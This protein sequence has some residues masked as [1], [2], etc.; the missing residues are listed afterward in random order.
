MKSFRSWTQQIKQ[1]QGHLPCSSR[2]N[3]AK[4]LQLLADS[5]AICCK[6]IRYYLKPRPLRSLLLEVKQSK[7]NKK[8]TGKYL[9]PPVLIV[10]AIFCLT[11]AIGH[12]FYNEPR[13]AIGTIAPQTL[14]APTS[15]RVIDTTTTEFNRKA[16]RTAAVP[17][18][19][20]NPH[21]NREI[22]QA[23]ERLFQ[24]GSQL[25]HTAGPFPFV[26]TSTLSTPTQRYLRRV[27]PEIWQT[28]LATAQ[29]EAISPS[30]P[31]SL[32]GEPLPVKVAQEQV[33][34]ELQ[35][36]RRSQTNEGF[37]ALQK[38][39]E[40]ARSQ[41]ASA[42]NLLKSISSNSAD[43]L[44]NTT[45]LDLT[46]AEWQQVQ[47]SSQEV[48]QRM[49][50]QG[51]TPGL[52]NRD[53]E[54][55]VQLQF[56]DDL[57]PIAQP[58]AQK[59]LLA[60]LKPNL[61][62]DSEQTQLRAEQAA[63]AVKAVVIKIRQGEVIVQ[64]G[65][66][67]TPE[68]FILLDY[69]HLSRRGVHWGRLLGFSGLVTIALFIFLGIEQRLHPAPLRRRD[70]FLILLLALTAPLVITVNLPTS[71]LPTIGLLVGSF[72]SSTLG[73]AAVGLLSLVLPLGVEVTWTT[74]AASAIGGL[75]G[76]MMA[77]R[78][79][80]REELALAGGVVGLTQGIVYLL[81]HLI[82]SSA[83]SPTWYAIFTGAGMQA[84]MG[85][86]WSVAALGISPYLE[87]FF[88]LVTP[89]RLAE[90]SNP[91]RPLLQRLAAEAPG[92]FQHT[93]FVATLAEAAAR[94]LGDNVELVRAGTL[95]HDIGKMHDPLGFIENQ[96]G[97]PNK[98]DLINN[99]WQSAEIIK[100]HVS[101]G[102]AMARRCRLPKAIQAFIP[103]HQGTLAISYFLHQ[104]LDQSRNHP[105][106]TVNEAD[107]HYDGPIPQTRET[108]IVMLADS[109][110]A[111]LRS[112]KDATP[113]EAL[114]MVNRILRARWQDNQ[115]VD[116]GLTRM[117]M[118]R[119]AEIFVQVWL[120]FNHQR[121][122][123]PK[124]A[125]GARD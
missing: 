102:L 11:S 66:R 87:Q 55:A 2:L 122:P 22:Q 63:E 117:E 116:S 104:A 25:R 45:F 83:E 60:V 41:Y 39:I 27:P 48:L 31:P 94:A 28:L 35:N 49:L 91:N 123:Y 29:D 90:L 95:Y 110:E 24:Q 38:Q 7:R 64:A 3:W 6:V 80:S 32:P 109:C 119:I 46:D 86:A 101:E 33:I 111:A 51:I 88:D 103:E 114:A 62:Q 124:V 65:E 68:D 10:L 20:V 93:L 106:L 69:F 15:A 58:L 21:A 71:N 120:Q 115:L 43:S 30:Q 75:V 47:T 78:L 4:G 8:W 96:M 36:Y 81:L 37:S 72:Y 73:V 12:R 98:H 40:Q 50:S 44:F 61:I 57:P 85:L 19:T 125:V 67:I 14:T 16:A 82:L 17:V 9:R 5:A 70:H 79:R 18:L 13:L 100:K 112:L 108:G 53:L 92:T 74:L 76:A 59:L 107:F 34:L 56:A 89:I 121:I 1:R 97:G 105:E 118:S 42:L 23:L 77:G 26:A 54:T 99:P 84:V 52:S 113:E